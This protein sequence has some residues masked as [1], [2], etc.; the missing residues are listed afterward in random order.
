VEGRRR[1]S[2]LSEP[3]RWDLSFFPL[4]L[5]HLQEGRSSTAASSCS[6]NDVFG[7]IVCGRPG[8]PDRP[9]P[10]SPQRSPGN[11]NFLTSLAHALL[12]TP[13]FSPSQLAI[14]FVSHTDLRTYRTVARALTQK[15]RGFF[16]GCDAPPCLAT[17]RP[18]NAA[19]SLVAMLPKPLRSSLGAVVF[20]MDG[21][22]QCGAAHSSCTRAKEVR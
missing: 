3:Q 7:I 18:C 10:A 16:L 22:Q 2:V 6:A 1:R 13:P 12:T 14:V 15:M 21:R 5:I 9:T 8:H 4:R 19:V 17:L 20:A 11:C